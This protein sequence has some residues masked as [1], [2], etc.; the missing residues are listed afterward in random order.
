MKNI[1]DFI[2]ENIISEAAAKKHV[3]I[4]Y[5][6][7]NKCKEYIENTYKKQ[8]I[9][10]FDTADKIDDVNSI[11]DNL[12]KFGN[13]EGYIVFNMDLFDDKKENA[14]LQN[15]LMPFIIDSVIP[16][17]HSNDID[18]KCKGIFC[19]TDKDEMSKPIAA[20]LG[21]LKTV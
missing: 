3:G 19:F 16:V 12:K 7:W 11:Y 9:A 17:Y 2:V 13:K 1:K 6:D 8:V 18:A 10:W 15:A 20:R 21:E 4:I 14:A 5:S